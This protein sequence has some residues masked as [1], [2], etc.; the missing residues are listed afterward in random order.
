MGHDLLFFGL[1][2][3]GLPR[4]SLMIIPQQVQD[5]MDKEQCHFLIDGHIPLLGFPLGR[6]RRYDHVAQ[7][8]G[9]QPPVFS[10][11]HR[12]GEDI[13]RVIT[14]AV[15]AVELRYFIIVDQEDAQLTLTMPQVA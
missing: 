6:L 14:G 9:M 7:D 15:A 3:S 5:P 10:L 13:G 8:L 4:V 12:K 1:H 2:G 11:P